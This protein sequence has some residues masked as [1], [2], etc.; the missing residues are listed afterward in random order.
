MSELPAA[1]LYLV[2]PA[3]ASLATFPDLLGQILD[4]FPVACVRLASAGTGEEALM[5]AADALRAVCHARE[6]PLLVADHFRLAARLGLDGVHLGDGARHL[7]AA[8]EE[9]GRDAIV[10]AHARASRH[11]GMTAGEIG[12]D[13]VAFG[14]VSAS[15]LGD[16][17]LAPLELFE[18]WSKT[19]EVPLVAEGGLT[20]DLAEALAPY[21]EFL[22]LGDEIWSAPEGPVAALAEF[23]RRLG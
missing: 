18:W 4:A 17:T 7:R 10:G 19:I 23:Q 9:L 13:Y 12:A 1:R 21:A 3:G 8:R 15:G 11:D 2:T 5:R 16:G 6:V 14:P 22:A 20:P